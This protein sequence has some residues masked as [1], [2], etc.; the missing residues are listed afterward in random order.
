MWKVEEVGY[1]STARISAF[2]G[3]CP[4]WD[5]LCSRGAALSPG[6]CAE[7]ERYESLT[8]PTPSEPETWLAQEFHRSGE[9]TFLHCH[10][11]S[12]FH[13]FHFE[14]HLASAHLHLYFWSAESGSGGSLLLWAASVL[15]RVPSPSTQVWHFLNTVINWTSTIYMFYKYIYIYAAEN[16]VSGVLMSD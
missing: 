16:T 5:C 6:G 13:S 3:V 14:K 1:C 15:P 9:W 11:L 10:V 4:N 2:E 8:G 7:R 12:V